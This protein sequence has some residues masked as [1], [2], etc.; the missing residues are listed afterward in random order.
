MK[1]TAKTNRETLKRFLGDNVLAV[2]EVNT[3]LYDRIAYASKM[4][5]EDDSKVTKKDLADLAKEVIKLLGDNVKEPVIE[6]T[7]SDTEKPPVEP[8]AENSVKK[9]HSKK[10][11]APASDLESTEDT[12][13]KEEDPKT[14]EAPVETPVEEKVDT[15][16]SAKKSSKLSKKTKKD[17]ATESS[18][19]TVQEEPEMFP[20]ILELEDG[21][22]Y[23]LATDIKNID[24]F[25]RVVNEEDQKGKP[26]FFA[27]Y[28]SKKHLKQYIYFD[29]LLGKIDSFEKDLDLA[30]CFY[31]S[32]NK[33]VVYGL[34]MYT[35]AFYT[36]LPD[37][38]EEV[39]GIRYTNGVEYQIYRTI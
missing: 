31:V 32:E 39:D 7:P 30:S 33:K 5:K 15:K 1:I 14:E 11:S 16:K 25:I 27:F 35:E 20:Q 28:W 19:K 29:G 18:K 6:E 22:K 21:S 10:E 12:S 2:K 37:S 24:D 36:V 34:S 3:E 8:Q 13:N 17:D 9:L 4:C 23:E 26:V 38:F